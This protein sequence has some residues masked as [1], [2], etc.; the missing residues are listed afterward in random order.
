MPS[1]RGRE[2]F[3]ES[4]SLPVFSVLVAISLAIWWSPLTSS[5]AL[6]L[7]DEQHTHI[8]LI[9]PISAALI[10][11]D[12]K[13]PEPFKRLSVG[14]GAV[15][16]VAAASVP[17]FMRR[18]APLSLDVR[19]AVNMLA[20]VVWW[21]AAFVSCFGVRAF[22]RSLF[23]LCFLLWLVPFPDFVLNSVVTLL[24][25][26]S[27]AAAH[28][29]FAAAGVP[30]EQRGLLVHIPGLTVEVA[31]ECSSIRSSSMLIVTTMVPAQLLLRSPWRKALLILVAIPLS[32]A[33][34]GLRIFTIAMLTTRVDPSFLT[35]KLHRQGG[36][37]FFLIALAVIFL[38]LWILRRGEE[39]NHGI[40]TTRAV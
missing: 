5:F 14:L 25:R 12:W 23:P 3:F 19:L 18:G 38:L 28:L 13:A 36:I 40:R 35:G 33:K 20:L 15:L 21:M 1:A 2:S 27:A 24:Q 17:F 32:V 16:L 39:T 37:I 11:M 22:R 30:V 26:G 10:V 4:S 8:L 6:A 9:L 7:R 29:L 34:N 31:R